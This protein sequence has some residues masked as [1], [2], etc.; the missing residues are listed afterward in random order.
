MEIVFTNNVLINLDNEKYEFLYVQ[1]LVPLCCDKNLNVYDHKDSEYTDRK[2]NAFGERDYCSF[3][4]DYPQKV[5]GV[6]LWVVDDE[7]IYIGETD[8][9]VKRFNSGYGKITPYNCTTK[10]Q[11]TNCKMNGVVLDYFCQ[12]KVIHLYFLPTTNYKQVEL[13]LLSN[14]RTKYNSKN[15]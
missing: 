1:D 6:Y 13:K 4:I 11:I 15:N 10:G 3:K 9:L 8:D 14:I 7:I 12:N 5:S 2:K